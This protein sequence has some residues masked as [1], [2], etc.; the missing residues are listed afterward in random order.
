MN[1]SPFR[2]VW[3]DVATTGLDPEINNIVQ[4]GAVASINGEDIEFNGYAYADGLMHVQAFQMNGMGLKNSSIISRHG[5]EYPVQTPPQLARDFL[6]FLSVIKTDLPDHQKLTLGGHNTAFVLA[7]LDRFFSKHNLIG[8]ADL[9]EMPPI[10]TMAFVK[11]LIDL[12]FLHFGTKLRLEYLLRLFKVD[13]PK[14]DD[15]F[16]HVKSIKLL[17]QKLS[18]VVQG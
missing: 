9:F 1:I 17:Y 4:I 16:T 5:T 14:N 11:V 3:V 12:G 8:I 6:D 15:A 13:T 7:F 18:E 10:D 2:I